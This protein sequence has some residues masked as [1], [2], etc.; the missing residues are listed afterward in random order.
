MRRSYGLHLDR[1]REWLGQQGYM[2][3]LRVSYNR[4][5]Q[6]PDREAKRVSDFLGSRLDVESMTQAVDLSLY[7]T[8]KDPGRERENAADSDAD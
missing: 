5:L 7:R 1:L 3:V 6:Q 4:L 2:A 8:R